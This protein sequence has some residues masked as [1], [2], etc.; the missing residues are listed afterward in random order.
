[1]N[2]QKKTINIIL[3]NAISSLPIDEMTTT[4]DKTDISI[5]IPF[6]KKQLNGLA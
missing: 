6:L 4:A 5:Q 2:L 3:R 1:M